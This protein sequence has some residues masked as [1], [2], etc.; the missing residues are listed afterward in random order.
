M[1]RCAHAQRGGGGGRGRGGASGLCMS[2][3]LSA[4]VCFQGVSTIKLPVCLCTERGGS[5][6]KQ[7]LTPPPLG[8]YNA[9]YGKPA[10]GSPELLTQYLRGELG[11]A[12]TSSRTARP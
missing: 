5:S 7:D 3:H 2:R 6:V 1:C 11:W 9:L 10:C 12:G 8:S 4:C